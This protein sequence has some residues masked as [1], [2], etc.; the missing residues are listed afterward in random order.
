MAA[1]QLCDVSLS[2]G[3]NTLFSQ[4]NLHVAQKQWVAILG[5]S[6]CGKSTLLKAIA[7][8]NHG[9][10]Q[11]GSIQC[12]STIAYMAQH[13]A[14]LPWLSVAHN[15]QLSHRLHGTASA[16]TVAQAHDMLDKVGLSAHAQKPPY[17]LSGG[18]RQRVAL[19][20]TLMQDADLVLMDEPFSAVDAI[21]RR[22]L[23]QLASHLLADKTVIFITHDPQEAICLGDVVYVMQSGSL[24]PA[25]IP[26]NL[27]PRLTP[28]QAHT[29]LQQQLLEALA[30]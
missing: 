23:Q 18:Q 9:A 19:A 5:R 3:D 12:N 17:T 22:E 24:S 28:S 1:L 11:H 15:V 4:L 20:R 2:F 8:L 7:G 27:R 10:T 25:Y 14:L 21:T 26:E 16:H 29:L 6:G 30:A 13:D